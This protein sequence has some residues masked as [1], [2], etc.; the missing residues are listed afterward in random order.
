LKAQSRHQNAHIIL[1]HNANPPTASGAPI[2]A[3]YQQ[4]MFQ[5]QQ[6]TP[7][8]SQ[9]AASINEVEELG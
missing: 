9:E 1:H 6:E 3:S 8:S 2:S 4:Q 7:D 5:A